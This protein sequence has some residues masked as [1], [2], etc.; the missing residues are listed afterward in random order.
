MKKCDLVMKG[1]IT[2]GIVYPAAVCELAREYRFASIGGTSAGAIAAALTAAAEY[3]REGGSDAGFRE[4]EELPE[5]LAG[6]DG[7]RLLSL[8]QPHRSGEPLFAAAVAWLTTRGGLPRKAVRA[9]LVL[10][11]RA[12]RV[13]A[14][15]LL[16]PLL[17]LAGLGIA[18]ASAETTFALLI[19]IGAAAVAVVLAIAA[20]V[21]GAVVEVFASASRVLPQHGYGLCS[22]SGEGA[23]TTWLDRKLRAIAGVTHPLTFGDL[24]ARGIDL[25]M[26]TTNLTHGRPYRF[27]AETK[28]FFF[29]PSEWRELFPVDVVESMIAAAP[30]RKP[31]QH[32]PE[33]EPLYPLPAG[34][35]LPVVVAARM[36]LSFPLLLSAVPLWSNDFARRDAEPDAERCWFSD[37]GITS[38]FPV[39][40]F[41]RPLPRWPTFAF[42]LAD[43]T[44]R[45]H[46]PGQNV[47]APHS[48]L[49]GL[50]EWWT[51]I[52][53]V[54]DFFGALKNTMQNWRDNML[55]HLPGQRDRIAHV[56]L[57]PDEGGLN[58]TMDA[59][60][61]RRVA[62]KGKEAAADLRRRF[63][64]TPAS[65]VTLTWRNHKWVRLRSFM[66]AEE[67]ALAS[68]VSA[69]R[70]AT[71]SPSYEDL[72]SGAIPQP[73]YR[74]NA[75]ERARMYEAVRDFFAHVR[76]DFAGDPFRTPRRRPRPQPV[77][78]AMPRE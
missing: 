19:A 31:R 32:T 38:N 41:D 63:A 33:S 62:A 37:G 58:L 52:G 34:Q 5:W 77:L 70:D 50:L 23:V 16:P 51:P 22:G 4:L 30:K 59:A 25:Q 9:I 18:I 1:G 56:L 75:A 69:W 71:L 72:L 3:R 74:V 27:P 26:M 76:E 43:W 48:N 45:Y 61:I 21:T 60:T 2:S 12:S 28:R 57:A 66:A 55:L 20:Y 13:G 14:V 7:K 46:Q 78:R 65:D 54:A 67:E 40:F 15:A 6:G 73:S 42:N 8:F 17:L 39:H 68:C 47:Y 35:D 11:R 36:S 44:S 10:L 64:D 53:T 29:S 24:A 49:S